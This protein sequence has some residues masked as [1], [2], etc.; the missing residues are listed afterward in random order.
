MVEEDEVLEVEVVAHEEEDEAALV[1]AVDRKRYTRPRQHP[2]RQP[3]QARSSARQQK[4]WFDARA[5]TAYP[6]SY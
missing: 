1:V 2:T 6:E 3:V 4:P 5:G